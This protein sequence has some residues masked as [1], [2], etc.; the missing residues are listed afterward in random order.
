MITARIER[1]PYETHLSTSSQVIV[2]DE[3]FDAGG[4]DRGMTP[5]DLL[6]GALASCTVITLRMYADRK[7]WP[8][9]SVVAHV[10]FSSDP[11]T[12][13]TRYTMKL[14]LN[15]DLTTDQRARLLDM[16]DRCPIHRTLAQPADFETTLVD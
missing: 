16:A 13:R 15:G 8:L 9:D 3:P 7:G 11:D 2:V 14:I 12:K 1:T 5:G 6:A 4:Q 10:D